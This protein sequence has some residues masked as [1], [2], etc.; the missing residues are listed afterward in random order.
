MLAHIYYFVDNE[1]IINWVHSPNFFIASE[2]VY[3]VSY[4]LAIIVWRFTVEGHL[5]RN[6][7]WS[8]T[9]VGCCL[10][11]PFFLNKADLH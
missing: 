8:I 2:R 5:E 6:E 10:R 9:S 4:V 1:L 11:D 3:E 7:L